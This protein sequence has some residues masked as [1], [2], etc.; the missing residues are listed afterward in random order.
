M[1]HRPRCEARCRQGLL[2]LLALAPSLAWSA[3]SVGADGLR[4]GSY[5]PFGSA[6]TDGAGSIAVTCD[7]GTAYTLSLGSGSGTRA[8]RRMAYGAHELKYNLYLDAARVLVW[9]DG[10]G[11]THT[12]TGT[13]TGVSQ[14]VTVYG[15]IPARQNARVGSYSDMVVLSVDF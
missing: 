11:T 13:G 9:G 8:A 12:V 1:N 4:F 6:D 3:C 14:I 15:R 10:I 7:E 5:D 2:L